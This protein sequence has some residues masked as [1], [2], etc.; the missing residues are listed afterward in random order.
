[1]EDPKLGI[2]QAHESAVDAHLVASRVDL[3]VVDP[4]R[5]G[6]VD[7]IGAATAQAAADAR[8]EHF[9]AERLGDVVVGT[10]LQSRHYVGLLASSRDHDDG[11]RSRTVVRL[12]APT[13]LEAI[14][15][16]QHQIEDD[17]IWMLAQ[18]RCKSFFPRAG[19]HWVEAFLGEVVADQLRDV[20][21]VF[22]DEDGLA[23]HGLVVSHTSLA[24]QEF[25]TT[26]ALVS[27]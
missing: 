10:E 22:D 19:T 5:S 27:G 24:L 25:G 20:F 15:A 11:D 14:E 1:M 8:D 2:G 18:R 4:Q 26:V 3:E 23:C 16:R 17:E 6:R 9:C 7:R 12:Q 13:N 21:F